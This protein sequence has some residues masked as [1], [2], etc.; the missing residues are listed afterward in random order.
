MSVVAVRTSA[1]ATPA[2]AAD[3]R[4]AL[5]TFSESGRQAYAKL[6]LWA[7][8]KGVSR[9][10][11]DLLVLHSRV[12]FELRQ[13]NAGQGR[14]LIDALRRAQYSVALPP[15]SKASEALDSVN[16]AA[17]EV[18]HAHGR[19]HAPCGGAQSTDP[20]FPYSNGGIGGVILVV[21]Y[22]LLAAIRRH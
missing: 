1:Q 3:I 17:H 12:Q 13:D 14:D 18:G 8:D 4:A 21:A 19:E 9:D 6:V 11:I 5:S 22:L 15:G 2:V 20:S 7:A 10:D 16:T